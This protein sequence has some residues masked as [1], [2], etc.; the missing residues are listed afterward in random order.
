MDEERNNASDAS[1]QKESGR[2]KVGIRER[3]KHFTWAW[4]TSTMSTGGLALVL[5]LTPH[6]FRG[7]Y[8]IGV[9]VYLFNIG[10]FL[11]L[12][13]CMTLRYIFSPQHFKRSFLHP[14]EAFFFGS[15]WLSV[16][17]ILS[18]TQIYG[19]TYGPCGEWLKTT[20]RILYYIYAALSLINSIQQYWVFITWT[21]FHSHLHPFTPAWFLA[22]YS[23][24]LTGTLASL[25]S[26]T[27][28]P[29]HRLP[30][31]VSGLAYQGFGWLLSSLLL[32][33]YLSNLLEKGL[34]PPAVRPG[35]FIP[36][37]SAAYT[38]VV[39]MGLSRAIPEDY[40]YFAAH[41]GAADTLQTMAL[42]VSVFLWLFAFYLFAIA[43][44]A[45]LSTLMTPSRLPFALPWWAFV[46]PNVGF[47]LA[48]V[49]IGRELG[50]EG[51]LWVGSVMTV[52]LVVMWIVTAVMCVRAVVLGKICWPG[53]DEDRE[54]F[55]DD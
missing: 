5:A 16:C 25:L 14:P 32:V 41:P 20:L 43:V 24:M 35:M 44:L 37:G 28:P 38:I 26:G 34:P 49:D 45:C 40:G 36:V 52:L 30:I 51:I 6:Q 42:F 9:I 17:V 39:L 31:I 15:F 8:T 12:C 47:T 7:L 19:V 23:S 18:G 46:F 13:T 2:V 1:E 10:L 33:L 3:L 22:G 55:K 29:E 27:Q 54:M 11:T 53:K 50:S 21:P 4:F 48:T